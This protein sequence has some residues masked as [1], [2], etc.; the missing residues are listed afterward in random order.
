MI[1]RLTRFIEEIS[2]RVG[3]ERMN[4]SRVRFFEQSLALLGY[5]DGLRALDWLMHEM[6]A[7]KG[8]ARHD[9]SNYYTHPVDCAQDIINFGIREEPIVIAAL[10]HDMAEDV[11]GVTPKMVENMFGSRVAKA[12]DLVTKKK[13][14]NYKDSDYVYLY[15][16]DIKQNRD[17]SIVKTA[18]RKHNFSTLRDALFEKKYRQALETEKF[19]I[20]FFKECRNL[21]PRYAHYFFAAKTAIEPH[22]WAIKAHYEEVEQLKF[23]TAYY[24]SL[25]VS[26][27]GV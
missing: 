7:E 17:A 16:H 5:N 13:D 22:L 2:K 24:E 21:Y 12:V 14:V 3:G 26:E 8:F 9:G 11:E 25:I 18:D 19:F 15:L 6:N 10:L 27:K 1:G 20:P 4:E 23:D